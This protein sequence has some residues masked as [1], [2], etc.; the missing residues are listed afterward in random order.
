MPGDWAERA[1]GLQ[2]AGWAFQYENNLYPDVDDTPVVL[3]A[4]LRA[5]AMAQERYRENLCKGL[6]WVLGMQSADGGWG[7]FEVDNNA[8][9]H[10]N[11]PF[12]DH[13]ALL[14]PST[15]DLTGRGTE[16][17]AMFGYSRDFPPVA[18]ALAFLRREQEACGA[19]YGRWGVNYLYGTWSVLTGLRRIGEDMSQPTVRKAVE[20]LKSCQ[21]QDHGW[22]ETCRSYSDPSLAGQGPSTPSQTAWALLALMAAGEVHDP[23]VQK[24]I[25]YLLATQ[26]SQGSWPED[27]F[28]GTGFPRVFYLRYHGY[29][30]YFP[31]WALGMY[32]R[33]RLG[34]PTRQEEVTL[35]SP[36]EPV[37]PRGPG[38]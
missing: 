17:L 8:L 21:N 36:P 18:K 12:A 15:S 10:N 3:M 30:L 22:G 24:G 5:D 27:A 25:E 34:E 19:W 23:A 7:A 2:P 33:L 11:I 29:R 28:T 1:P 20:W 26:D 16:L 6:R 9:Y 32:R 14:D 31:L 35:Q 13:G 38:R 4:L 37:S